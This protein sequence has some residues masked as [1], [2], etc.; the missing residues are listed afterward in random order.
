MKKI[1]FSFFIIL[2]AFFSSA[3]AAEGI[4]VNSVSPQNTEDAIFSQYFGMVVTGSGKL[5]VKPGAVF[6]EGKEAEGT[7][8]AY[9]LDYPKSISYPQWAVAKGVQG[10]LI[11]ALDIKTDGTVGSYEVMRSSGYEQL[12]QEAIQSV[13]SWKFHPATKDGQPIRTCVQIPISFQLND[14]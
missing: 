7:E 10:K 9:L 8:L 5:I 13:Q 2:T 14:K 6:T 1:L 11:I 3:Y 12:D 4:L